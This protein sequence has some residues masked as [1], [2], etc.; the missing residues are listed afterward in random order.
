M[1]AT[2]ALKWARERG[3]RDGYNE[4]PIDSPD[5]ISKLNEMSVATGVSYAD[6]LEEYEQ[7]YDE[8]VQARIEDTSCPHGDNPSLCPEC[9]REQYELIR[10]MEIDYL[11][12]VG[13]R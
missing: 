10:E 1:D 4:A 5:V 8:G 12:Q 9:Q 3:Y 11:R 13:L 2:E 7:S 6:L